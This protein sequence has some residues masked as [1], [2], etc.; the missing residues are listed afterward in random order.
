MASSALGTHFR[1][2]SLAG[3]LLHPFRPVEARMACAMSRD[4]AGTQHKS[5]AIRLSQKPTAIW[6]VGPERPC[7]SP[8]RLR[9]VPCASLVALASARVYAYA[10]HVCVD[11]HASSA[12]IVA[13]KQN[14]RRRDARVSPCMGHQIR[15]ERRPRLPCGFRPRFSRLEHL[16]EGSIATHR[17]WGY[18]CVM[19]SLHAAASKFRYA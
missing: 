8:L 7:A 2:G 19:Q 12:W 13:R 1:L 11:M 9:L 10:R 3:I 15:P 14:F 4:L 16:A 17:P 18:K 5:K 6:V